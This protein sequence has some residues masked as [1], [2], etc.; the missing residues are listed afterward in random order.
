[1]IRAG[2]PL[3][4]AALLLP[5][6]AVLAQ[7]PGVQVDLAAE[8]DLQFELGVERYRTGDFRGALE[9]LLASNRLVANRN[10]VFNIA[11][12]YE[13]LNRFADAYR[14]Y[15]DFLVT[16]R[17]T[18]ER[19][20]AEAALK[21]LEP[22]LALLDIDSTPPGA[23][24]F[25]D[26]RDLGARGVTPS[27]LA[28]TPGEHIV[29]VEMPGHEVETSEP[30]AAEIGQRAVARLKLT[31]VVGVLDVA[32][33]P[34]GAEIRIDAADAPVVG[35]LPGEIEV[36]PGAH[37]L[38]ISAPGRRNLQLPVNVEARHRSRVQADLAM[39]TGTVVVDA[40]E[41]GALIEIDGQAAGFA[42]A[43]LADVPVGRHTVRVSRAGTRPVEQVIDLTADA[44]AS[45]NASL[46]PVWQVTAASRTA[47]SLDDAPASVTLIPGTELR[48][49]GD[50]T[51][52]EALSGTRGVFQ[53]DDHTYQALGFRGFSRPGD[54]GNRV[55]VLLDGHPMNDDQLGSS[56][57]GQD[58]LTDLGDVE[59]IEVVRGPGSALYG[60]NAFFGVVNVVTHGPDAVPSPHAGVAATGDGVGRLRLGGGHAFSPDA[61]FW[62]S[63]AG[64]RGDGSDLYLPA[65]V[66]ST[67]APDGVV[68]G[69]DTLQSMTV[70]GRAWWRAVT[71]QVSLND[72]EKR[73]P[74][75]AYGTIPGDPKAE[76]N[77]TRGF[78][79]V[80][81][82]PKLT[83][84]LQ[85]STRVSLDLY[86][87]AGAY[88]YADPTTDVQRD[89]WNGLW[90]DAEVRL[91][92]RLA[93][94]ITLTVGGEARV[95]VKAEL[96]SKS[97]A[98][99]AVNE[100]AA[101]RIYSGYG[102]AEYAPLSRLS[103]SFGARFD[104]FSS[105]DDDAISPRLATIIRPTDASVL[106]LIAGQAFRAPSPY[107]LRYADGQTQIRPVGLEP[108]TVRTLEAE[109][110]HHLTEDWAI[111]GDVF[112]NQIANLISLEETGA[113]GFAE[114]VL[115]YQNLGEKAQT[116]GGELELRRAWQAGGMFAATYTWQRTR[117]GDFDLSKRTGITNSPEHL[118]GLKHA[119]PIGRSGA[120]LANR[121]RF[122]TRRLTEAGDF[123]DAA[124]LWDITLT[125]DLPAAHLTYGLGFRNVLDQTVDHPVGE[126][127]APVDTV[128][129][130]GRS[131]FVSLTATL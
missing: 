94:P 123:T 84:A 51:L 17:G 105:L 20:E 120:T 37:T 4:L 6:P 126:E 1:V 130:P 124:Y 72:R 131:V 8:A 18:A 15:A 61:G 116:L 125:G 3:F 103:F 52:Y 26:R 101:T 127:L 53:T 117:L 107:E 98:G 68:R 89:T 106:K 129:Q 81:F 54:Y 19:Q 14:H 118:V 27:T 67:T 5:A 93:D 43:V 2:A 119:V 46:R 113:G 55:L 91:R 57:V 21:R 22:R 16:E 104:H 108:E 24:I 28:V 70:M 62:L 111:T 86:R 115:Q 76:S 50:E 12:C 110:T 48:A 59:R 88:P 79:E 112:F 25:V 128:P 100:E 74:T 30:M 95:A 82:D 66:G 69:A 122:E 73:I 77:D 35:H 87:F 40:D 78:A 9:H 29:I 99:E 11:R 49:F 83:E 60:S 33:E 31:R 56:Y 65:H 7:A 32:G 85:L 42:P 63:A 44:R 102:V 92:A 90:G 58:F 47:E 13:Q 45:I 97:A 23:T 10:V 75:G 39:I 36:P 41:V 121:M 96:L 34:A 64:A 71:L 109:Y 114:P 80:R 38:H